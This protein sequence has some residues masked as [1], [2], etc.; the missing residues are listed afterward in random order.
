MKIIDAHLHLWDISKLHYPWL[1]DVPVINKTFLIEDYKKATEQYDIESMVFVQCEC[2]PE[3]S[4][5]ELNFVAEQALLDRRIKAVIAYAPLEK[6][7]AVEKHL[8][9]LKSNPMVK[10]VRRMTSNEPG[11]CLTKDFINAVQLLVKYDLTLDL[12]IK[13]FQVKE[14]ISLIQQCPENRF[15]LDHLGKPD[16]ANNGFESFKKDIKRFASL[17]N[18]VA[19]IS[20]LI[21]E[22]NWNIWK[23]KDIKPYIEFAIEQFGFD[24]LLFG[25]DYPVVLLAGNYTQWIDTLL[26]ATKNYSQH[27]LQNLFYNNAKKTYSIL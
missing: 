24:R 16:I 17:P 27:E 5:D 20:G 4:L 14:T 6:G 9:Q 25:S 7:F 12:S 11:L 22:A 26:E 2:L 10:G 1:N 18:V 15:I 3:E 21:T 13:P 19:K 23:T 8:Q